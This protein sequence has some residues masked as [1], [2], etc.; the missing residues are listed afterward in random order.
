MLMKRKRNVL[1]DQQ[2]SR[3]WLASM[4]WKQLKRNRSQRA[5]V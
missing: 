4:I 2:K 1:T 3:R 5:F